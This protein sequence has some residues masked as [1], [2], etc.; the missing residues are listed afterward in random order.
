[1][2][3]WA[4]GQARHHHA[5]PPAAASTWLVGNA[6]ELLSVSVQN[7]HPTPF[8]WHLAPI[9]KGPRSLRAQETPKRPDH[10]SL[11]HSLTSASR[12][13]EGEQHRGTGQ[14]SLAA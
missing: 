2:Q 5:V 13:F 4:A 10:C 8:G 7:P 1:V 6:K 3:R 11:A 14:S 9:I 12:F